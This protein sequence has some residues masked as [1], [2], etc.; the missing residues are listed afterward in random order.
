[1][2]ERTIRTA[3]I[4]QHVIEQGEGPL[5]VMCHGFPELAFSWRHQIPVLAGAGCHALAP[6][7][8]G[9]GESSAPSAIDAYDVVSL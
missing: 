8:R 4:E 3:T 2:N 5:V 7:M 9:F 1:M 6:D